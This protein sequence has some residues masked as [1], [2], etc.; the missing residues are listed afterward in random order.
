MKPSK[1]ATS[2]KLAKSP[3]PSPGTWV[4]MTAFNS[5]KDQQTCLELYKASFEHQFRK[6]LLR[7]S[8]GKLYFLVRTNT[9][10]GRPRTTRELKQ[11]TTDVNRRGADNICRTLLSMLRA[12]QKQKRATLKRAAQPP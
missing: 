5:E 9:F 10:T 2:P 6:S 8:A 3:K 1:A 11:V 12:D 7:T 4:E